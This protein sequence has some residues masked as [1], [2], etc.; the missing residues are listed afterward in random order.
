MSDRLCIPNYQK[1]IPSHRFKTRGHHMSHAEAP[2]H[3]RAAG[4]VQLRGHAVHGV[5]IVSIR[6]TP[7]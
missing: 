4:D 6:T 7:Y 5:R 2:T 3:R 1:S